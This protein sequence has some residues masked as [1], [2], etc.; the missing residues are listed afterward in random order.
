MVEWEGT[1]VFLS[2]PQDQIKHL[3]R[4]ANGKDNDIRALKSQLEETTRLLT[5][6]NE[7][8]S[9]LLGEK[10]MAPKLAKKRKKESIRAGAKK[11]TKKPGDPKREFSEE[12]LAV[13]RENMAKARAS[14]RKATDNG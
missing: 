4:V 2:N 5:A 10:S 3:R 14:R 6:A 13:L 9:R 7:R 1:Q 8:I 12:K 11:R